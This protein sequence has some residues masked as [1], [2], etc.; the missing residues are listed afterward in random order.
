MPRYSGYCS[1]ALS[2]W[3]WQFRYSGLGRVHGPM[4]PVLIIVCTL[5][6]GSVNTI[7]YPVKDL[8][9]KCNCSPYKVAM[10][11][12]WKLLS[13]IQG[14]FIG[15]LPLP[16]PTP[17]PSDLAYG[18]GVE[19]GVCLAMSFHSVSLTNWSTNQKIVRPFIVQIF[20]I[21][22]CTPATPIKTVP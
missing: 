10:L 6:I 22:F 19:R 7:M 11:C 1:A 15:Q 8:L 5:R 16:F 21:S 17:V 14:L 18:G 2:T 9:S 12:T 20:F 3:P 13:A 4:F